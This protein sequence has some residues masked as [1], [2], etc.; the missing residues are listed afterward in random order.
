MYLDPAAVDDVVWGSVSS[1]R[2]MGEAISDI[3]DGLT[4]AGRLEPHQRHFRG[5]LAM[6]QLDFV[7][8]NWDRA[9]WKLTR[10]QMLDELSA[11]WVQ[12]LT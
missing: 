6:A 8:Q 7:G 10:N 3:E 1:E 9:D 12:L 2:W 11:S 5:V 4:T